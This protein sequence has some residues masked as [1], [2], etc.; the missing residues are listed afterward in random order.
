MMQY[1]AIMLGS[2]GGVIRHEETQEVANVVVG[3]FESMEDAINQ[4]CF[5]LS[6][7]HLIKGVISKGENKGG[8]MLVTNQ[9]LE[10]I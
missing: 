10:S 7:T 5:D 2:D 3:D 8:F 6:C 4:A 1:V 9:D